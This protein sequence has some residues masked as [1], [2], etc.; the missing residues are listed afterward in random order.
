MARL[1]EAEVSPKDLTEYLDTSSDFAFELKVQQQ[2]VRHGFDCEHGGTYEDPI[3]G[4][5]RQFDLRARRKYGYARVALAVECKQL[6]PHFPLMVLRVPRRN[7]ES[8][9]EVLLIVDPEKHDIDEAQS[10]MVPAFQRYAKNLRVA[11]T[12]CL[13]EAKTPVGKSCTQV[14][15]DANGAIVANSSEAFEKWSQAISSARGLVDYECADIPSNKEGWIL[16]M[17]LPVMVVPDDRLWSADFDQDGKLVSGPDR[18]NRC[19]YLLN[20]VAT[21]GDQLRSTSYTI[22]H[23]EF[24]TT[25]GLDWLLDQFGGDRGP[26]EALFPYRNVFG[27]TRPSSGLR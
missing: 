23:V 12:Q 11:P 13:Y 3:S 22:S 8:F 27:Q 14:G 5:L 10:I 9:H 6:R 1:K 15:R 24:V 17:V 20:A 7:E 25:T 16:S 19:P 21:G 26:N 4:K 18:T 2:L